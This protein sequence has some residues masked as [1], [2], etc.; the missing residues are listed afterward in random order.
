[1]SSPRAHELASLKLQQNSTQRQT[2]RDS[3]RESFHNLAPFGETVFD[4]HMDADATIARAVTLREQ[5]R[6]REAEILYRDL[7]RLRPDTPAALEGLGIIV[8][9]QGKVDEAATLFERGLAVE[10][11]SP[12]FHSY[13][14]EALRYLKRFD[15]AL[16]HLRKGL[17]LNP[18]MSHAWN[19]LGLL[20]Y[21]Q[22]RFKSAEVAYREVIRLQPDSSVAYNN[23]G[24]TLQ[25]CRRWSEAAEALRLALRSTRTTPRRSLTWVKF[26]VKWATPMNW[27][28]R[29]RFV[30]A[31]WPSRRTCPG[32]RKPRQLPPHSGPVRR[33]GGLL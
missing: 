16:D 15:E 30:D 32:P 4:N 14:G 31:L 3:A 29:N 20:A 25:A 13:L 10:P 1:M 22:R 6:F 5:G 24:N 8:Y 17:T 2:L 33:G 9:Q 23:L 21:D 28:M 27:R 11:D 26:C 19:S 18:K 7:L 12:R